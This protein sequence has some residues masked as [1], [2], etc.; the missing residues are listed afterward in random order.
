MEAQHVLLLVIGLAV[1]GPVGL[2]GAVLF[3]AIASVVA[4]V[5]SV[6]VGACLIASLV[7]LL[8][9]FGREHWIAT[10]IVLA[11]LVACAIAAD[12]EKAGNQGQGQQN[13]QA[14]VLAGGGNAQALVQIDGRRA[15]NVVHV[16]GRQGETV[17]RVQ[18]GGGRGA[19]VVH[20]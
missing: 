13:A 15:A 5:V 4:E 8:W 17:V 3:I 20:Y 19:V 9:E 16:D 12:A 11:I 14:L 6:V 2:I 1:L 7:A 18:G 10:L